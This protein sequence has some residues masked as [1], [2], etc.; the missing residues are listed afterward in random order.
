MTPKSNGSNMCTLLVQVEKHPSASGG[1]TGGTGG[2]PQLRNDPDDGHGQ[3]ENAEKERRS[4][5]MLSWKSAES[6]HHHGPHV[7]RIIPPPASTVTHPHLGLGRPRMLKTGHQT[8]QGSGLHLD[9]RGIVCPAHPQ[10]FPLEQPD[11]LW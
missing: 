7:N 10:R 4:G 9:N 11:S 2:P 1:D 5:L 8:P 6:G 3:W